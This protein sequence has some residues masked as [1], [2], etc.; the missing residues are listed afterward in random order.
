MTDQT[1]PVE[2]YIKEKINHWWQRDQQQ[3]EWVRKC[4]T[5]LEA[6]LASNQNLAADFWC[7]SRICHYSS[8]P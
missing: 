7:G 8:L 6:T 2:E 3:D 5:R 1:Q 4:Y